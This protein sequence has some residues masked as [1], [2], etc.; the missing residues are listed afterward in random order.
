[1]QIVDVKKEGVDAAVKAAV[2]VLSSGG[3]VIYPTE[4]TYGVGV[5]VENS[6]AVEKLLTYKGKRDGKPIS[7]AVMSEDMAKRYVK[8]N[9]TAENVYKTFLPGPVTVVSTGTGKT[10]VGI[11]S[12]EGKVGIRIPKYDLALTLISTFGRGITA[13]GANASNKKRPYAI[14]DIFDHISETQKDLIDLVLDVGELPHNEPSTVIDTTLDDLVILRSGSTKFSS[15]QTF[16]SRNEA[17]TIVLF[18]AIA[19]RFRSS[20]TYTPVIFALEGKMGAG[21]THAVKGLARGLGIQQS[22][23]SP[24]YTLANEYSFVNEERP[25]VFIHID[26][27]AMHNFAELLDIGLKEQIEKNAVIAIEWAEKFEADIFKLQSKAKVVLIQI[28]GEND[29]RTITLQEL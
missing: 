9:K 28:A 17:E 25:G 10:V 22:I 14:Q 27:W 16:H 12:S 21:K 29:E 3:I 8:L 6:Q 19:K 18:E 2:L 24:T 13:T 15:S 7:V 1:M 20:Y 11:A 4:T 23:T 5:D 26:A